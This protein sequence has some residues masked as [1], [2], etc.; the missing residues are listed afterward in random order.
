MRR[1]TKKQFVCK[2]IVAIVPPVILVFLALF[3]LLSPVIFP[4]APYEYHSKKV[5]TVSRIQ[6][7]YVYR[8]PD[9]YRMYT[10]DGGA[11]TLTGEYNIADVEKY[12]VTG[13]E[14]EI[15]W[16]E[17]RYSFMPDL[18][19]EV[20]VNGTVVVAYDNDKPVDWAPL[21]VYAVL[22]NVLAGLWLL[23]SLFDIKHL[24][25]L[26]SKRDK[27]IQKKYGTKSRINNMR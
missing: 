11:Y 16:C 8:A 24:K 21:I 6:K 2:Y 27:R 18:A 1:I 22:L 7:V 9:T 14:A 4:E 15:L 10:T 13:T 19:E 20:V 17:N 3:V 12:L 26:Q 25:T 5:V 23:F